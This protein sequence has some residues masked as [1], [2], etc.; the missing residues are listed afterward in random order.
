MKNLK[1]LMKVT[2][3]LILGLFISLFCGIYYLQQRA[4]PPLEGELKIQGLLNRVTIWRDKEGIPHIYAQNNQD[5]FLAYGYVVASE[6]LFQ[7]DIQRRLAKGELAE[8]FGEK[9]LMSDKLF[10]TLGLY[11]HAKIW[12]DHFI[13]K[14]SLPGG[15]DANQKKMLVALES[16][17]RGVNQFIE[18]HSLPLEYILLGTKPK[19]FS[20]ADA[21]AFSG[22]MGYSFGVALQ[23]EPMLTTLQKKIGSQLVEELRNEKIPPLEFENKIVFN[24]KK[25]SGTTSVLSAMMD[26]LEQGL[27]LFHGSNAWALSGKRTTTGFPILANDPHIAYS[28]PGIW[29]EA[30]LKSPDYHNYGHFIPLIPFPILAYNQE[31]GWGLTMS[32]IDDMDIYKEKLDPKGENYYFKNELLPLNTREEVILVKGEATQILKI[33]STHHGPLLGNLIASKKDE[34]SD[35]AYL[36]FSWPYFNANNKPLEAIFE[37]GTAGSMQEFKNA[38]AKGVTPGL[39]VIYADKSDNIAWWIMGEI[40]IKRKD[41]PRDFILDGASGR[42]EVERILDFFDAKRPFLENPAEGM[43]ITANARPPTSDPTKEDNPLRGD[44]QPDDRYKT[45]DALLSEKVKWSPRE[46][47]EVQSLSANFENKKLLNDLL[48]S[49]E[50]SLNEKDSFKAELEILTKWN[51]I[52]DKNASAPLI[53]YSWTQKIMQKL[54]IPLFDETEF[55]N[56]SRHPNGHLFLKR[57]IS[58]S[59]SPWWG[60]FDRKKVLTESFIETVGKLRELYGRDPQKWLWGKQHTLEF[61]HP[62][63]RKWPLSYFF[64]LGPYAISGGS[65]EVNNQKSSSPFDFKVTAGP[66]TRRIIDFKSPEM[67]WGILP[68]GNSGHKLSPYFNNQRE[69]FFAG[70]FRPQLL[71]DE[72]EFQKSAMK[73]AKKL[74]LIP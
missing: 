18:G 19:P 37:M 38:V 36:S 33:K 41:L 8:I 54:L 21:H 48:S 26:Q 58:E 51:F 60:K 16:F 20:A 9:A 25:F 63:G 72:H 12:E 5:L 71:V 6:R 4:L 50:F 57:I 10:R 43:I 68:L 73:F 17:F 35:L 46:L 66:S 44:W 70:E 13:K 59:R 22:Y 24:F 62:L 67:S 31:R 45:L 3:V 39:N 53:F 69:R 15:L 61:I 29:F 28:L 27:Y 11:H 56:M 52:S 34:E 64:N 49:L 1:S 42:D 7:M 55:K 40:S 2:I 30:H 14:S 23:N 65:Q 32:L 47:M 74:V